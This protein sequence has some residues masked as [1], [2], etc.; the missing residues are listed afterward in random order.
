MTGIFIIF[1]IIILLLAV[2]LMIAVGSRN[3][4][5][6][7]I[8]S[9]YLNED[10]DHSYYDR[11]LIEKKEFQKRHPEIKGVRTFRRLFGT[12]PEDKL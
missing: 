9:Q 2:L 5:D 1:M 4:D 10:G 3:G 11:G 6:E 12:K 7:R 8:N